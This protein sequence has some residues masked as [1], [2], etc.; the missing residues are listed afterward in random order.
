MRSIMRFVGAALL[1][2]TPALAFAGNV[3]GAERTLGDVGESQFTV[4]E[5]VLS[6]IH[7]CNKAEVSDA[8][9][10]GRISASPRVKAFAKRLAKDHALAD[11]KVKRL[12]RVLG[13]TMN[14]I[15][16]LSPALQDKLRLHR[17]Q[18]AA[19]SLLTGR[20]FDMAFLRHAVEDHRKAVEQL[21]ES[22]PDISNERL[23]MLV[24]KLLPVL[25][26]HEARAQ[27]ILDSFAS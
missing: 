5:M 15:I 26:R 17:E 3:G 11:R 19:L 22:L 7:L 24:E 23:K 18:Q 9:L 20:E 12:A 13:V 6:T 4:D 25:K 10:V 16:G 1:A 21:E 14:N 2:L 8:V 27:R